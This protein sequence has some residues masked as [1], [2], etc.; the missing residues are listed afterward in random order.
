M[1]R[2]GIEGRTGAPPTAA[3]DHDLAILLGRLS[4][5]RSLIF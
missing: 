2:V 3:G 1:I 5:R 4:R